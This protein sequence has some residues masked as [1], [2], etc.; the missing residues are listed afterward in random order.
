MNRVAIESFDHELSIWGRGF[1]PLSINHTL[2]VHKLGV[3][4]NF[5]KNVEIFDFLNFQFWPIF[6]LFFN[7]GLFL[8]CFL[9]HFLAFF[10]FLMA[11]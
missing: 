4:P 3:R 9:G 6:T 7:F 11:I 2:E 8:P 10:D 1:D 5:F